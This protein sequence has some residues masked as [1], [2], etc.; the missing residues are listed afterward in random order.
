ML[1]GVAPK[2]PVAKGIKSCFGFVNFVP[3]VVVR[4]LQSHKRPIPYD[5][6]LCLVPL[7]TC[8]K[9]NDRW[10]KKRAGM[11]PP[12]AGQRRNSSGQQ[13][14]W[15]QRGGSDPRTQRPVSLAL[16]VFCEVYDSQSFWCYRGQ[17]SLVP[18]NS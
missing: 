1:V 17:R 4:R 2:P 16:D 10:A 12:D 6:V 14:P 3:A 5:A 13:V 15:D 7:N 9:G 11:L 8:T 18:G